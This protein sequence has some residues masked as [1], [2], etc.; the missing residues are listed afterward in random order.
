[1]L[2]WGGQ[3]DQWFLSLLVFSMGCYGGR[4]VCER[5]NLHDTMLEKGRFIDLCVQSA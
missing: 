3:P 4:R 5:L 1:M 2:R